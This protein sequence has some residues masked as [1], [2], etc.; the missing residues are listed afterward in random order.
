MKGSRR[1]FLRKA[2][3]SLAALGTL[4]AAGSGAAFGQS[5]LAV[6]PAAA[7]LPATVIRSGRITVV[8]TITIID[9][10]GNNLMADSG[11]DGTFLNLGQ[12]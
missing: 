11:N 1:E 5:F 10:D 8:E 3:V 9:G 7:P 6:N 2:S 12:A 4:G